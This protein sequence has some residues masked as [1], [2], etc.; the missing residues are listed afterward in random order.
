MNVSLQYRD[1]ADAVSRQ[2]FTDETQFQSYASLL[3]L[4][5]GQSDPE[6]AHIA[7]CYLC[8]KFTELFLIFIAS[9]ILRQNKHYIKL[10]GY[11]EI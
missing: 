1:M 11:L 2:P 9:Y 3:E 5:G 8:V 6:T 7:C 10:S 4:C